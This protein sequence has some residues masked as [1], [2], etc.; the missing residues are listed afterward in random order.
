MSV[1]FGT[2]SFDV[3]VAGWLEALGNDE[4]EVLATSAGGD[5]VAIR[6]PLGCG[7]VI[8]L[9]SFPGRG[10]RAGR[11]PDLEAFVREL[12]TAAGVLPGLELEPADGE[13]V[14]WRLGRSGGARLLFIT[15]EPHVTAVSARLP[16]H[17]IG[18]SSNARVIVGRGARPVGPTSDGT[19]LE[20]LLSPLGIGVVEWA[21]TDGHRP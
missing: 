12:A 9:G 15:A 16:N 19:E 11:R 8:A 20:V 10:Y 13:I 18:P 7:T 14:Q 21:A 4:A 17:L 2:R 3:P 6:R 1:S 5:T